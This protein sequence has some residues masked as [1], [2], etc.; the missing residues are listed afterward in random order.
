MQKIILL[1]VQLIVNIENTSAG[2]T[3]NG[4]HALFFQTFQNDL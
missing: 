2:I 1:F 4:I 3:E